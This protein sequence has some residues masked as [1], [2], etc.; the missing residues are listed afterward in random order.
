M[1]KIFSLFILLL[2]AALPVYAM[3]VI[4]NNNNDRKVPSRSSVKDYG[5][6]NGA[7]SN[8]YITRN[9]A[10]L[11]RKDLADLELLRHNIRGE[12][13]GTIWYYYPNL[14][15]TAQTE[16]PKSNIS[17][18]FNNPYSKISTR[19]AADYYELDTISSPDKLIPVGYE[20]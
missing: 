2:F 1:K 6:Y 16:A 18:S 20:K 14:I 12:L 13:I 10:K 17:A 5:Y 7:Y 15:T 8:G 4:V 19:E 9:T 11:T 3:K